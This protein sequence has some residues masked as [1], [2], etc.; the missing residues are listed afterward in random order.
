M[1]DI[2]FH[3]Q[4]ETD[5]QHLADFT[6]EQGEYIASPNGIYI[7]WSVGKGIEVWLQLDLNGDCIGLNPHF[8][9]SARMQ[10]G[11]ING[12]Q[13]PPSILDGAFHG[14]ANPSQ[15]DPEN[16]D[17]PFIFDVPDYDTYQNLTL[18]CI[19]TVQLAAFAHELQAFETDEAFKASQTDDPTF[20][21][22]SFFP[23]GLFSTFGKADDEPPGAFAIFCGH[24][25][26][27]ALLTNPISD[28]EF[29]WAK[30]H[31]FGGEIDVIA[32]PLV[33]DGPL[34]KGGVIQG[35]FWLSGRL[36]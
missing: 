23:T 3:I 35:S 17:Y 21:S 4:T 9:G 26:E 18:P 28:E 14:W 34:V 13:R 30:V 25:L 16:G 15:N 2:G 29:Y 32:D 22:E 12:I 24:V 5:F 11:L 6:F 20:A 27:S 19:Q 1:S 7:R 10:V 36:V 33:L 31:T 8:S